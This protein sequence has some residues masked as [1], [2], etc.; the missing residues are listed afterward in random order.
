MPKI[1]IIKNI[2]CP[3]YV[4]LPLMIDT[5]PGAEGFELAEEGRIFYVLYNA[6]DV[7]YRGGY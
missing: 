6:L 3:K 2:V 5:R 4:N 7:M 1:T